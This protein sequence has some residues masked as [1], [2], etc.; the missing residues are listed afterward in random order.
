[1][2]CE[3]GKLRKVWDEI[4]AIHP[5]EEFGDGQP[6]PPIA[7]PTASFWLTM[8]LVSVVVLEIMWF[9]GRG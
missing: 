5:E 1:M 4:Q 6:H 3:M 8:V 9:L 2:R 7:E